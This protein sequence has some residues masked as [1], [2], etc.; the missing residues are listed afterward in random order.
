MADRKVRTGRDW[1]AYKKAH[2]R[3]DGKAPFPSFP[4]FPSFP[5]R[6][7]GTPATCKDPVQEQ[8]K[9]GAEDRGDPLRALSR[10]VQ[11]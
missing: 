11:V 4:S 5:L 9:D 8:Q 1:K 6:N 2:K 7:R 10:T 3:K